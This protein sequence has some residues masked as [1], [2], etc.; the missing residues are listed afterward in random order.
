MQAQAIEVQIASG[1]IVRLRARSVAI[2]G[3]G[4]R[5]LYLQ[6]EQIVI[7]SWSRYSTRFPVASG[8][9][10]APG[11]YVQLAVICQLVASRPDDH[12]RINSAFLGRVCVDFMKTDHV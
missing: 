4:E 12:L 11:S 2:D 8:Q 1:A 5:S 9:W 3:G 7:F 6:P 10:A